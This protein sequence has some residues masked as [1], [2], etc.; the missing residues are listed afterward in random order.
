MLSIRAVICADD[1]GQMVLVLELLKQVQQ[2]CGAD[3]GLNSKRPVVCD[4]IGRPIR[5]LRRSGQVE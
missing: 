3:R 5:M 1:L 4:G 2:T